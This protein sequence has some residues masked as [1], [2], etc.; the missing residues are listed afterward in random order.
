[1]RRGVDLIEPERR[2]PL[3]GRDVEHANRRAE[4]G[5]W[6]NAAPH[7]VRPLCLVA[8]RPDGRAP[9]PAAVRRLSLGAEFVHD[10]RELALD[11]CARTREE[12]RCRARLHFD[13]E[14]ERVVRRWRTVV[15]VDVAVWLPGTSGAG[16]ELIGSS[17][18]VARFV[19]AVAAD[20]E[21]RG[22]GAEE[23][24]LVA[25]SAGVEV[26]DELRAA[27]R[28][29][30]VGVVAATHPEDEA[31]VVAVGVDDLEPATQSGG[32]TASG[33]TL[34]ALVSLRA[35]GSLWAPC[36]PAWPVGP[37]WP[38]GPWGPCSPMSSLTVSLTSFS[39]PLHLSSRT[40]RPPFLARQRTVAPC[41]GLEAPSQS[42]M[43]AA[44]DPI[45][46]RPRS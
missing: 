9:D 44:S 40:R 37:L 8:T 7:T 11:R 29:L 35:G 2:P 28:A 31:D 23:E 12:A 4:L 27:V 42:A 1:T 5:A 20:V 43:H 36:A 25:A 38:E 46:I 16:E 34:V 33:V 41:A 18:E 45:T 22:A 30:V 32:A 15:G 3:Q 10:L 39:L 21:A 19:I 17:S 14:G 24:P 6:R 26:G 13:L